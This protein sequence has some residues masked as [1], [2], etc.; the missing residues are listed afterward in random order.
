MKKILSVTL[1]ALLSMGAAA[2]AA[3]QSN[4]S[5]G[6]SKENSYVYGQHI[7][8]PVA[9]DFIVEKH[10]GDGSQ[11]NLYIFGAKNTG[12]MDS[13]DGHEQPFGNG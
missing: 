8:S 13:Y 2:S 6:A 3:Q 9:K 11:P 12:K 4:T 7:N 1:L 5:G 10:F